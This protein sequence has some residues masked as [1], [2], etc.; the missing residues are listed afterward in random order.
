VNLQRL[1]DGLLAVG[2]FPA[3]KKFE[4]HSHAAQ[5]CPQ[6]VQLWR[7]RPDT[8]SRYDLSAR[9]CK[10]VHRIELDAEIAANDGT[11]A[12]L[13]DV[14]S[15]DEDVGVVPVDANIR[16][17]GSGQVVLSFF[18]F[19]GSACRSLASVGRSA[20]CVVRDLASYSIRTTRTQRLP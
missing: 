10:L 20:P 18:R 14:L 6:R 16:L 13:G 9:P 17:R 5:P 15:G 7:K 2:L 3:L 1:I 12:F 19:S 8:D 4:V 11:F